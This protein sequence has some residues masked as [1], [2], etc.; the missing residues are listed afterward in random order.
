[1]GTPRVRF[2]ARPCGCRCG[3]VVTGRSAYVDAKHAKRAEHL[4]A[5]SRWRATLGAEMKRLLARA[6]AQG[7]AFVSKRAFLALAGSCRDAQVA[8]RHLLD[9]VIGLQVRG[10][11]VSMLLRRPA[12]AAS[13]P[14]T[15][16]GS[17]PA[18]AAGSPPAT[19]P[20]PH[21]AARTIEG[22]AR[23]EAAEAVADAELR[24]NVGA[25]LDTTERKFEEGL[26]HAKPAPVA[27]PAPRPLPADH[28][29]ACD[30]FQREV[31]D[32]LSKAAARGEI[33][34]RVSLTLPK[35]AQANARVAARQFIANLA[36]EGAST[37]LALDVSA[38]GAP[39]FYGFVVGGPEQGRE[40]NQ[41]L[42]QM[43]KRLSRA[44]S[45]CVKVQ[46]VTSARAFVESCG[47]DW[48]AAATAKSRTFAEHFDRVTGYMLHAWAQAHDGRNERDL[49]TDVYRSGLFAPVWDATLSKVAAAMA[50]TAEARSA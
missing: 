19:A 36:S 25:L 44:H 45:D 20:G 21:R 13:P 17:P 31:R 12:A 22:S 9:D 27:K 15:A 7:D 46:A 6:H 8:A 40:G 47:T 4:R 29:L 35:H 41:H 42:A 2:A 3:G 24:E 23:A 38:D 10:D 33:V 39:H 18:T 14:A 30:M 50:P 37:I 48:K 11:R 28:L 32:P 43:W 49:D 26:P 1:M 16:A 34:R 5:R